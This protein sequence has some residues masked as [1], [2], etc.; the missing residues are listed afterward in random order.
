MAEDKVMFDPDSE[1]QLEKERA[2]CLEKDCHVHKFFLKLQEC[3]KRVK[4]R[5]NT[6]ETCAEETSDLMEAVDH[7]VGATAFKQLQ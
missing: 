5:T 1:D 2:V 4:S 3:E 6:A 7:C